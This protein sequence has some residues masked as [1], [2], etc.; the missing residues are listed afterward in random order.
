MKGSLASVDLCEMS[1]MIVE[2]LVVAIG[3]RDRH[4]EQNS[5]R[6]GQGVNSV[7]VGLSRSVVII[8]TASY[9]LRLLNAPGDLSS[10]L[11]RTLRS[12]SRRATH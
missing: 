5:L 9:M 11:A 7:E 6:A 10:D 12:E 1:A 4:P 8:G 3:C 2:A